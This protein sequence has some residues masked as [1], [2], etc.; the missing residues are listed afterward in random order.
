[1]TAASQPGYADEAEVR[2]MVERYVDELKAAGAIGSA[3]VERAFRTVERHRLLETFY[4]RDAGGRKTIEHDPGRPQRDH[5]ALIY[6]D[7]SE[8]EIA[9]AMG[10]SRGAVKSHT[11]RG[12]AALR[13]ALEHDT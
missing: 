9:A 1:M 8:A 13:A 12:M 11:S 5:L 3:A 4:L 6:A 2:V 10:I 7:L